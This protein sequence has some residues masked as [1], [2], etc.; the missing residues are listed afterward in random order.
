[1]DWEPAFP[2]NSAGAWLLSQHPK[3]T[4]DP[5]PGGLKGVADLL[6]PTAYSLVAYVTPVA[7]FHVVM[8]HIA[9]L[10]F[11]GVWAVA[12]AASCV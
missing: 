1:M 9:G 6:Q 7:L 5:A 11:T 2:V 12:E 10:L 4:A 3:E 8:L